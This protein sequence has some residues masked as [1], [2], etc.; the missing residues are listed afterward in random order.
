MLFIQ[1]TQL[2]GLHFRL[3]LEYLHKLIILRNKFVVFRIK[4]GKFVGRIT[5]KQDP[6]LLFSFLLK[7]L[8]IQEHLSQ[9]APKRPDIYFRVV[10]LLLKQNFRRS[11]PA[12]ADMGRQVSIF[13]TTAIWA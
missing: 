7:P 8:K 3:E 5:F 2:L 11:V 9:D 10:L 13:V 12:R 6:L 1:E 4:W